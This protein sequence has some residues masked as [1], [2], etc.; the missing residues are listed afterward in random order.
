VEDWAEQA[1]KAS[2]KT[3]YGRLAKVAAGAPV[4]IDAAYE[5]VADPLIREQLE[6]AGARLAVVL[7]ATLR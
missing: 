7:N 2:Q 3:V 5:K 4:P 6:R 1:H